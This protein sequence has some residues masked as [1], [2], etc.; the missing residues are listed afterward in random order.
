MPEAQ[1]T[2]EF[3]TTSACKRSQGSKQMRLQY[4]T[5]FIVAQVQTSM[6][7]GVQSAVVRVSMAIRRQCMPTGQTCSR[8]GRVTITKGC[9]HSGAGAHHSAHSL[10]VP[11]TAKFYGTDAASS[12]GIVQTGVLRGAR[13][14]VIRELDMCHSRGH[15]DSDTDTSS[16]AGCTCSL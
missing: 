7:H 10:H 1:I 6:D 2:V 3:W 9:Q 13:Q 14:A 16:K 4:P 12:F 11:T 15:T 8:A 5:L